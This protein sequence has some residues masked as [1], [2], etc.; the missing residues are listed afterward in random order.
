LRE[1]PT[2]AEVLA[3]IDH[4][5]RWDIWSARDWPYD[6]PEWRWHDPERRPVKHGAMSFYTV[7]LL[8]ARILS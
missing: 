5:E 3:T 7:G 1:H 6:Q 8:S 4:R 2:Y